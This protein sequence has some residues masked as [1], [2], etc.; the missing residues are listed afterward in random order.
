MQ[1]ALDRA[2]GADSDAAGSCG[3]VPAAKSRL[4]VTKA[5][6]SEALVQTNDGAVTLPVWRL[7]IDRLSH[8]ISVI[9]AA[10]GVLEWRAPAPVQPLP[11]LPE[12]PIGLNAADRLIGV[13]GA[14]IEIGIGG[15][16]CG[17]ALTAHVVELDDMVVGVPSY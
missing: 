12:P 3:E 10:D 14:T 7:T 1:A 17:E 11:G 2:L 16:A 4:V 15:G 5:V 6:Q 13:D 8:P 9:A